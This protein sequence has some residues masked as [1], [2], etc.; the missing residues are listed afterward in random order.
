MLRGFPTQLGYR[1]AS[2]SFP[3]SR[4]DPFISVG[5]HA[6]TQLIR[7]GL[8]LIAVPKPY[9]AE[10]TFAGRSCWHYAKAATLQKYHRDLPEIRSVDLTCGDDR[11]VIIEAAGCMPREFG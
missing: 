11:K 10:F 7:T 8:P 5:C 9:V 6:P 4:V 2:S 1:A 3:S